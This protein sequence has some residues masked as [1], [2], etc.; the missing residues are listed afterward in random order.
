EE[1]LRRA[2]AGQDISQF[3][4]RCE[5]L[6]AREHEVLTVLMEGCSNKE[7]AARLYLSPRSVD[8]HRAAALAKLGVTCLVPASREYDILQSV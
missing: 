1:S 5:Q 6:T 7:V 2:A 4:A 8:A 3:K